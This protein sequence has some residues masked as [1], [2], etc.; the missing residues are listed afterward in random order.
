[1]LMDPLLLSQRLPPSGSEGERQL[2]D[3]EHPSLRVLLD[4]LLGHPLQR[5][6]VILRGRLRLAPPAELADLAMGVEHQPG[7]R[8]G[9]GVADLSKQPPRLA[10]DARQLGLLLPATAA[11]EQDPGSRLLALG[12]AQDHAVE[13]E[14]HAE[15]RGRLLGLMEQ[16]GDVVETVQRRSPVHAQQG[17]EADGEVFALEGGV[18]QQRQAPLQQVG[19]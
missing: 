15:I 4:L 11:V 6:Q 5:T 17:V 7:R 3:R 14:Q 19:G 18:Q 12:G 13:G 16:H 8:S 2:C 10:H 1:M 9:P